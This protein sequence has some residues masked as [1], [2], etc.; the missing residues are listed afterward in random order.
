MCEG[1]GGAVVF[2]VALSAAPVL[3]ADVAAGAAESEAMEAT[4]PV[5]LVLP[6]RLP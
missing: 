3:E 5:S 4:V 6:G 2:A 1:E